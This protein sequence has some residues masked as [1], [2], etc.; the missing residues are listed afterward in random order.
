M[1]GESSW[2]WTLDRTICSDPNVGARLIAEVLEHLDKYSWCD[3]DVFGIHMA[4]EEAVMNAIK[5]GNQRD[6]GKCV[7]VSVGASDN[8]FWA[9]VEDEGPGFDPE[10]VPDPTLEENIE[11]TCGRGVMLMRMYMDQVTYNQVGNVVEISKKK[12]CR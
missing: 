8:V 5:H 2:T 3:K 12:T 10:A 1:T 4:M 11:K 9:R 6:I 7:K